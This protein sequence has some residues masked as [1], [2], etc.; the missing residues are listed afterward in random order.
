LINRTDDKH[1]RNARHQK[2]HFELHP[3]LT[4]LLLLALKYVSVIQHRVRSELKATKQKIKELIPGNPG[5][6]RSI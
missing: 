2:R 3:V 6:A 4:R 5:Q 1:F